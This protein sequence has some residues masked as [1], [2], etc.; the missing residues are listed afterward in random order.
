MTTF[1]MIKKEQQF[2]IYNSDG[3]KLA[4]VRKL[5]AEHYEKDHAFVYKSRNDDRFVHLGVKKGRLLFAQ[6]LLQFDHESYLFQDHKAKTLL[7]YAVSGSIKGKPIYLE[8]NWDGHIEL[9]EDGDKVAI[10]KPYLIRS[11][12]DIEILQEADNELYLPIL[13]LFYFMYQIYKKESDFIDDLIEE[14]VDF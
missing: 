10:L 2:H 14:V 12:A 1:S 13:T 6:Y 5:H 11:G 3:V 9:K 7:Y 8:E 4:E